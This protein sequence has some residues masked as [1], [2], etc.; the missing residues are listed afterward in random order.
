MHKF[1]Y[2]YLIRSVRRKLGMIPTIRVS[3]YRIAREFLRFRTTVKYWFRSAIMV[4]IGIL[5][6][7]FG[8]QGFLL[9]SHFIDGGVMG[10]SL[11]VHQTVGL[12]LSIAL[13][14]FNAPFIALG[15]FQFGAS[16][17]LKS[18]LAIIGLAAA[19][20]IIEFPVVTSDKLLVAAFGGIF[21]GSGI[22]FAMRGGAVI[23]GTEVLAI[24]I[25]RR[26]GI[27]IGDIILVFNVLIFITAVYILSAEAAMYSMLTYFAASKMVDFVVEGF[28]EYIGVTIIS[29]HHEEVQE[30]IMTK[31]KRGVTVYKGHGGFGK[32]GYSEHNRDILFSVITRIELPKFRAE[33]G[34]IDPNVFFVLSNVLDVKGGIVKQRP[35]K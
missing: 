24:Y 32:S 28:E 3:R 27:S 2:N 22:G 7:G 21:L 8:L 29:T 16:F 25:S 18:I 33:I 31:M 12:S 30:M 10:I 35:L 1:L 19:V 6:A 4:G 13:V 15:Y 34:K 5:S 26:T 11:M 17:A 9:P 20:A 23:D 14:V